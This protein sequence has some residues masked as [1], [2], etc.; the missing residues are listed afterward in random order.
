MTD[1]FTDNGPA[2]LAAVARRHSRRAFDG[3]PVD[4]AQL[5]TLD[6]VCAGFRPYPDARTVLV[7]TPS[8]DVFQGVIGS[9]GKVTG[10]PH[11]LLFIGDERSDTCDQHVGYAG[12]AAVLEATV[13]GLDTC[14]VGGFFNVARTS[15]LVDLAP[16]ERVLA[17]SPLGH[18]TE[19]LS[20]SERGMQSMAGAHKRKSVA[21]IA[22][23]SPGGGWRDWAVAAVET[24]RLAPSAVNRQPWRFR[25]DAGALVI[26]RDSA[27]EFPRV[28]KRLDCGIAMLHA[29][30]GARA[31]GV[32]G[33]WRELGNGLD[34]ARFVTTRRAE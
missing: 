16:G 19:G 6:A 25:C 1:F 24:A 2:W 10:A 21:Q 3:T 7:R 14:W 20:L 18:A 12:Q 26:A 22:P 34:V 17:V 5:D 31:T 8:V 23:G 9:Y 15:Q 4:S 27:L 33:A 28:T 29:E 30:L 32:D 11:L 13:L